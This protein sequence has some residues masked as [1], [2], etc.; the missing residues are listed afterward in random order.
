MYIIDKNINNKSTIK[1][2]LLWMFYLSS[3]FFILY[4]SVNQYISLGSPPSS[5]VFEWEKYIPFVEWWVVPYIALYPMVIIAFLLPQSNLELRV[6]VLRSFVI[7]VFSVT[8]FLFFPLQFSF[9][10][11]ETDDFSWFITAVEMVDYPFNQAPSLHVSFSVLLWFTIAQRFQSWWMNLLLFLCFTTI[12]ISTLFVYQHHFI[13]LITGLLVGI[14]SIYFLHQE[15]KIEML[16]FLSTS[17]DLQMALLYLMGSLFAIVLYFHVSA[18]FI[19]LFF[20]LVL[21]SVFWAFGV[22]L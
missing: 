10:R 15:S 12:A 1:I 22:K 13:D 9:I 6:L 21:T 11:P 3:I 18:L 7:I 5:S 16:G 20:Y 8:V 19:L 17:K 14:L 2:R 4:G